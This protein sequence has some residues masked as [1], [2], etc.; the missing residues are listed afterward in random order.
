MRI[1]FWTPVTPARVRPSLI[2]GADACRSTVNLSLLLVIGY[3]R[4][5]MVDPRFAR[6]VSLACH[7][8]RT[9]LATVYGFARTLLRGG[10]LDE[11]NERFVGM[12]E[13]AA[14]QMTELLD[15]LAAVARISG[16]RWEPALRE[17]D[18][19]ELARSA[20]D[21]VAAGGAGAVI[22]TEVEAVERALRA[23]AI[24]AIR[25]GPVEQVSWTVDGRMLELAPVTDAAAPIVTGEEIRDLG[26]CVA[27]IV[28]EELGGSLELDGETL[29]VSL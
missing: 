10:G 2:S 26:A 23:L 24:A 15:A 13:A 1:A 16:G 7:D 21:R 9:P 11:R 14:E 17:V 4:S 12:I 29:R 27:R 19:L 6:L 22:E 8:L 18:T 28:I 25:H 20:D 3:N 5:A